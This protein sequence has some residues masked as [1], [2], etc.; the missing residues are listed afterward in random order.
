MEHFLDGSK[1]IQYRL[2]EFCSRYRRLDI[3][4]LW[5]AKYK[6]SWKEDFCDIPDLKIF[7]CLL[8]AQ[9]HIYN[10]IKIKI[11]IDTH[12]LDMYIIV[13]FYIY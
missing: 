9:I 11:Y 4:N 7:S 13:H 1:Y 8:F 12:R 6:I 10:S 2:F 5:W 3:Y